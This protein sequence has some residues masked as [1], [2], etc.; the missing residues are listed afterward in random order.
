MDEVRRLLGLAWPVV[1]G[2]LGLVGMGV[3]DLLMVGPLGKEATASVGIG[4]TLSFAV[5]VLVLGASAGLEPLVAQAWG[6]GRPREAGTA[7][8]R[9]FVVGLVLS[10]PIMAIHLLAAPILEV[11]RQPASAIP[12]AA[13]FCQ[14]GALSVIPFMGFG[15]L[16]T[17]LQGG[18][19]MRP[20][21]WVIGIANLVNLV[22]AFTFVR[23]LGWGVAGVA[24]GTTVVRWLMFLVLIQVSWPTIRAAWP[25]AP[26]FDRAELMRVARI[27]L[28]VSLQV[29]LEVWAFNCGSF[30]AGVL[31][32]TEVAAHTAAL[33]A[34]SVAFMVP[35]GVSSAASTR[36]GNLVGAGQDWRRAGFVSVVL[37]ASL[38]TLSATVFLLFP[39]W[40]GRMYNQDPTVIL[41]IAS[42]LPIAACFQWFDGT[43]VVSFGVLRGL[44]DTRTPM[45]F[46]V[47]GYWVIGLPVGAVLAFRGGLGLQGVW[48]GLTLG[49]GVVS[50]LLVARLVL[51]GRRLVVASDAGRV[52]GG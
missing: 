49:L 10:V 36:V 40:V 1:I 20:A 41:L 11:L 34:A 22:T 16:R 52:L 30:L 27:S 12:N 6:A 9:G 50:M 32:D 47:L 23:Y 31:G 35:L 19:K 28:P 3:V 48:I 24:W 15:V 43:Q 8:A 4:N 2:Q 21:M 44:G 25:D 33:S 45:L 38:M 39:E 13:V 42:V 26:I 7:T 5:L 29:G 17:L 46:N 51:Q 37:G 14:I 18:G